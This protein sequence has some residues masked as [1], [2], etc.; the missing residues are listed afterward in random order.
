MKTRALSFM[1][2]LACLAAAASEERPNLSGV[3]KHSSRD[4]SVQ[5]T[6]EQQDAHVTIA[7]KSHFTAGT[8]GGGF[9]G[10]ETYTVDGIERNSKS[11]K[12]RETWITANWQ[13][14]AL[15]ILRVTKV[16]YR[17]TV[18][19]DAWTLSA[20]GQMLNRNRRTVDMD[21]VTE[22]TEVFEKQ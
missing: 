12:G 17:V 9:I 15:V 6:I 16:G 19:R 4:S 11:D 14:S 3:W 13:G 22:T 1:A 8:L 7:V 18:T 21:G 5:Y 2:V 10:T 20:D